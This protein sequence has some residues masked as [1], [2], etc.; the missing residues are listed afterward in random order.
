MSLQLFVTENL[1]SFMLSYGNC[2]QN[3]LWGTTIIIFSH[4]LL[5]EQIL[6][7]YSMYRMAS[8]IALDAVCSHPEC[9]ICLTEVVTK[10]TEQSQYQHYDI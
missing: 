1:I 6:T 2:W 7:P 3:I 9:W 4:D 8:I 5:Y 10:N